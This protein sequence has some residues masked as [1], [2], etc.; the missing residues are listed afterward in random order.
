M[1][2]G[3]RRGFILHEILYY[4]IIMALALG[5]ALRSFT[6]V[7]KT[8]LDA[9]TQ[10]KAMDYAYMAFERIKEDLHSNTDSLAISGGVLYILKDESV[11]GR[12]IKLYQSADKLRYAVGST[13]YV[14]TPVQNICVG[15][16][17]SSFRI[18]NGI[19]V[20]RLIFDGLE[21]ERG[22]QIEY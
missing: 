4:M 12:Y 13:T 3:I 19:L 2:S 20:I 22:F 17:S 9:R 14:D 16:R 7:L 15:L 1:K 18:E 6:G 10:L 8:Y 11:N 21:L 5:I